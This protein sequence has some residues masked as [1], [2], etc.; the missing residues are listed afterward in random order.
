MQGATV[1][2]RR[3]FRLIIRLFKISNCLNYNSTFFSFFQSSEPDNLDLTSHSEAQ[4]SPRSTAGGDLAPPPLDDSGN[5]ERLRESRAE[6]PP[7]MSGGGE[8]SGAAPPVD[9]YGGRV[10]SLVISDAL[11]E[12]AA[13]AIP[14]VVAHLRVQNIDFGEMT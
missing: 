12:A 10:A 2:S 7:E 1:P 14:G 3:G 9:S 5:R 4:L 13:G 11:D 6:V 8:S